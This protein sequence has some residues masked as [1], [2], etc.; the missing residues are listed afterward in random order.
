MKV[1]GSTTVTTRA[2]G[3]TLEDTIA[4]MTALVFDSNDK[5]LP[6]IP[7]VT[8]DRTHNKVT[9]RLKRSVTSN[10]TYRVVLLANSKTLL[11]DLSDR[12]DLSLAEG[13]AYAQIAADLNYALSEGTAWELSDTHTIPMWGET[14]PFL[15]KPNLGTIGVSLMRAMARVDVGMNLSSIANGKEAATGL[16]GFRLK[17]I[18]LFNRPLHGAVI[19]KRENLATV[20]DK[21]TV[22]Q[23][24][25]PAT[26]TTPGTDSKYTTH[27]V[28][29]DLSVHDIYLPEDSAS[30]IG[31]KPTILVAGIAYNDRP[32]TYY[33]IDFA[34]TNE[35]TPF[36]VLRNHRYV[37]N[38]KQVTGDG[39]D[40]PEEAAASKAANIQWDGVDLDENRDDEGA[41]IAGNYYFRCPSSVTIAGEAYA[42]VTFDY[43]TNIP[44]FNATMLRWAKSTEENAG[45]DAVFTYA[46]DTDKKQ[47][48]LS[49]GNND[50]ATERLYDLFIAPDP[51]WEFNLHIRRLKKLPRYIAVAHS[52]EGIYLPHF[53]QSPNRFL[54][55][56]GQFELSKSNRNKLLLT[57]R[58]LPTIDE[59][60]E[61]E[62]TVNTVNGYTFELPVGKK[63]SD[64]QKVQKKIGNATYNEYT[65]ELSAKGAPEAAGYDDFTLTGKGYMLDGST[66]LVEYTDPIEVRVGYAPKTIL[67]WGSGTDLGFAAGAGLMLGNKRNFSMTGTVP[68]EKITSTVAASAAAF[69]SQL[70]SL[71]PDIAVLEGTYAPSAAYSK[72]L[73]DYCNGTGDFAAKGKG[74]LIILADGYNA[75]SYNAVMTS[76]IKA[77]LPDYSPTAAVNA[78]TIG[79]AGD[80]YTLPAAGGTA[81]SQPG[82]DDLIMNGLFGSLWGVPWGKSSANT[83]AA[84]GLD[85][86]PIK[87]Y[88]RS[89]DGSATTTNNITLFRY[90][91]H[92]F[93]AGD[94]G[95]MAQTRRVDGSAVK[96]PFHLNRQ[97]QPVTNDL[98]KEPVYNSFVM[99][100]ILFWAI[101]VAEC[102]QVPAYMGYE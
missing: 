92:F 43:D 81:A 98:Y 97:Y 44:D 55:A 22:A 69:M 13:T 38:I 39:Y 4:D 10:D 75:T 12:G 87:V 84:S 60:G 6:R 90:N 41:Y 62:F 3:A 66:D 77:I 2:T 52:V 74:V 7:Y 1:S 9:L 25:L 94:G 99:A 93:F 18:H 16:Q 65:V 67:S 19:P 83:L 37:F 34:K 68:V 64:W 54:N 85:S 11:T 89:K 24:S 29:N 45:G 8:L 31:N 56:E 80:I 21:L 48:T 51:I 32:A 91:Q 49:A 73:A 15:V 28:T 26:Q 82:A 70:V 30:G 17:S 58:T 57:V 100:N 101:H 79:T 71:K 53:T 102:Q 59:E 36:A 14:S 42:S 47:I 63:I 61:F 86:A 78:T 33:R 96:Y 72:T 20:D 23:P 88:T 95:F 5:L 35:T 46:V 76:L 50:T 27:T 40:T